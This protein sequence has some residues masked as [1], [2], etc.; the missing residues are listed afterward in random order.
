MQEIVEWATA[1]GRIAKANKVSAG[2]VIGIQIEA[3]MAAF[4]IEADVSDRQ[5]F[6]RLINAPN[7]SASVGLVSTLAKQ[8]LGYLASL[9]VNGDNAMECMARRLKEFEEKARAL[10]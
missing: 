3:C 6:E 7:Q 8:S 5:D 2:D 1:I 4:L 10:A 9:G